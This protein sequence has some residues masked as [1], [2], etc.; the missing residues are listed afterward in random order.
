MFASGDLAFA[1]RRV[2]GG[3]A[4]I[5]GSDDVIER[6][7]LFNLKDYR[8]PKMTR[9]VLEAML[10]ADQTGASYGG[11]DEAPARPAAAPA[12]KAAKAMS[13]VASADADDEPAQATTTTTAPAE[14]GKKLS[15]LEQ[16]KAR[17]AAAK[18]AA[19]E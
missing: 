18:A 14:G 9:E 16:L 7:E 1:R 10:A 13:S 8:T 5:D 2:E 15:V 17:A 6:L 3:V 4:G 19:G 12:A 11:G